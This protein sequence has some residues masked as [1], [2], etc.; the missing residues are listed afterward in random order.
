MEKIITI[1]VGH[2]A[3]V[4]YIDDKSFIGISEERVTRIKNFYGFPFSA[5]EEI[6]SI[7]NINW[8]KINKIVFTSTFLENMNSYQL[9]L[10]AY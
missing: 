6:F 8:S 3:T 2:D 4:F 1:H 10:F 7:K 5:I 9:I